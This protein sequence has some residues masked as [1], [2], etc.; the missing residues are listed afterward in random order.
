[1]TLRMTLQHPTDDGEL[2]QISQVLN[3]DN[4]TEEQRVAI[5]Q[6]LYMKCSKE[7]ERMMWRE[8]ISQN[9]S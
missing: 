1:M 8:E 9:I 3:L 6:S 5:I 2:L 4:L 7:I